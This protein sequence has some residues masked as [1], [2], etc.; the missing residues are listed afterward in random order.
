M[1]LV[2][3]G[4][5]EVAFWVLLALGMAVRYGLGLRRVSNVLLAGLPLVDLVLLAVTIVHLNGG[6]TASSADAL[7]AIYIGAS[8]AGGKQLIDWA[9]RQIGYRFAGAPKPRRPAKYG[10]EHARRQRAGWY[11]HGLAWAIGCA[12]LLLAC[13]LVGSWHRTTA[14]TGTAAAWTI[15]LAIDFLI[16]FSYTLWPRRERAT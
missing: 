4:C 3:I 14:L 2:A 15:V 11:R 10:S 5:C 8:V 9:D 12:L 13:A 7:A 16:S 6:A 1:L